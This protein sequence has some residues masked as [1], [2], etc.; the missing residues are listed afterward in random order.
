[1]DGNCPG[2]EL[3]GMGIDRWELSGMGNVREW[4][5]PVGIVRDGNCPGWELSGNR[6]PHIYKGCA[7]RHHPIID[8]F[9][10]SEAIIE[11]SIWQCIMVYSGYMKSKQTS[12]YR[13][14]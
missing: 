11:M 10:D 14:R 1:M 12:R 6:Y 2:W 5:C 8:L 4:N 9:T 7:I 3:S 13:T